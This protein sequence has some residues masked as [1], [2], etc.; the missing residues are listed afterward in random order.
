MYLAILSFVEANTTKLFVHYKRSI[1][2][3][4]SKFQLDR[5]KNANSTEHY[6]RCIKNSKVNKP[7]SSR[8]F[9]L[10]P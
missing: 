1:F 5:I 9:T 6:Y 8:H 4:F 10:K 2:D 3:I 7:V